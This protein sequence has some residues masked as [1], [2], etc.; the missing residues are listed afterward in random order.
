MKFLTRFHHSWNLEIWFS[1]RKWRKMMKWDFW[2]QGGTR[3]RIPKLEFQIWKSIHSY[4]CIHQIFAICQ[5][6][7]KDGYFENSFA[8]FL[9]F[10][11]NS[12]FHACCHPRKSLLI[13]VS[14]TNLHFESVYPSRESTNS[15]FTF[16]I[17]NR[18]WSNYTTVRTTTSWINFWLWRHNKIW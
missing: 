15:I 3:K 18:Y 8:C 4:T 14:M 12:N 10:D 16:E 9:G 2:Y 6:L 7:P 13:R 11:V 1:S 5:F 17:K